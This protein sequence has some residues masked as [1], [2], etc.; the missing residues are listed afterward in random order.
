VPKTKIAGEAKRLAPDSKVLRQLYLLSGNNCA[1]P[2]CK[3]VIIDSKG[4]M[5]GQICHIEAAMPNGAR[6]NKDQTD[7]QRRALSNL[8]LIC[9]NHHIEIDS[10]LHEEKWTVEKVRKLKA[11]HES[12]FRA[13]E[14]KLEQSY[15]SQFVDSTEALNP[16]DPGDFAAFEAV[17][18]EYGATERSAPKR[19]KQV[20]DY[21]KK[22]Q[23][24]PDTERDFMHKVIQR[25]IR[26]DTG[27][28]RVSV[29][30][31]DLV[32]AFK[33]SDRRVQEM[34]NALR[35]YGVGEL[36]EVAIGD[37]D[38][39]HIEIWDPSDHLSWPDIIEFCDKS[40]NALSDFV[41]H[42]KFGLLNE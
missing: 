2:G 3:H 24:V 26:L 4:A 21:I 33:M 34:G 12:K 18:P 36:G 8:V 27:R 38:E 42:L 25:F 30:A 31:H 23:S 28:E 11:D 7:E 5:I 22:M 1:M 17:V 41:L 35:R 13:I 16:T 39:W 40:G 37:R 9:A 10:K 32:S 15:D 6:F 29:D 20:N 14:G 19:K